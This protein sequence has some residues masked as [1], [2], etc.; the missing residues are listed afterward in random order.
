MLL[1]PLQSA[2]ATTQSSHQTYWNVDGDF[3]LASQKPYYAQDYNVQARNA[4]WGNQSWNTAAFSIYS[5]RTPASVDEFIVNVTGG[6][7]HAWVREDRRVVGAR[8]GVVGFGEDPNGGYRPRAIP[9]L[10]RDTILAYRIMRENTNISAVWPSPDSDGILF[11][12]FAQSLYMVN[13]SAFTSFLVIDFYIHQECGPFNGLCAYTNDTAL[14]KGVAN[15]HLVIG[16]THFIEWRIHN[17]LDEKVWVSDVVN[18]KWYLEESLRMAYC[19]DTAGSDNCPTAP[20]QAYLT[21]LTATAE[22]FGGTSGFAVDYEYLLQPNDCGTGLDAGRDFD[23]PLRIDTLSILS[24]ERVDGWLGVG[25]LFRDYDD[26]YQF[27]VSKIHTNGSYMLQVVL[28]GADSVWL[29]G[30]ENPPILRTFADNQSNGFPYKIKT[31]DPPGYWYLRVHRSSAFGPYSLFLGLNVSPTGGKPPLPAT[32]S[33]GSPLPPVE[34]PWQ[35]VVVLGVLTG[36]IVAGARLS[37]RKP[38]IE[39]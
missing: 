32:C 34:T 3:T 13:G 11:D 4:P 5:N 6:V 31:A 9:I 36:L 37:S 30:S 28:Q 16:H 8:T 39:L 23:H 1:P 25:S 17:N 12:L 18:L 27:N 22:T 38:H 33:M 19:H 35:L 15:N 2:T 10:G 14:T 7:G 24:L 21:G 20:P 26:Y 29:Y